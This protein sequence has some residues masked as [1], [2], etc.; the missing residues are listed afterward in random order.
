M[1]PF[2]IR[3]QSMFASVLLLLSFCEPVLLDGFIFLY[4]T[5]L[6]FVIYEGQ[7]RLPGQYGVVKEFLSWKSSYM[8]QR[9]C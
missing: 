6:I 1:P 5:T 8:R 4:G 2:F 7:F 3:A 9:R